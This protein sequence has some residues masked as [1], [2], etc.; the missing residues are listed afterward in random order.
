M[1]FSVMA[2]EQDQASSKKKKSSQDVRK[3]GFLAQMYLSENVA[4]VLQLLCCQYTH[5]SH[6]PTWRPGLLLVFHLLFFPTTV[7]LRFCISA[8][9]LL[10]ITPRLMG[11]AL[12]FSFTPS[13]KNTQILFCLSATMLSPPTHPPRKGCFI[14]FVFLF[15]FPRRYR[16]SHERREDVQ[17]PQS[18]QRSRRGVP[19]GQIS[20]ATGAR[21]K[22]F[23]PGCLFIGENKAVKDQKRPRYKQASFPSLKV[24]VPSGTNS[25]MALS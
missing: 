2:R 17:K 11:A 19:G 6:F 24:G 13:C 23:F 1:I 3:A 15:L 5:I 22:S 14:D 8:L 4:K 10:F 18:L 12:A 16:R 20:H 7:F 21:R 9:S 25:F